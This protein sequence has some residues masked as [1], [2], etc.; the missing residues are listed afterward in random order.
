MLKQKITS[1]SRSAFTLIELLVVIAIIAILASLLLPALATAKL[2]AKRIQCVSNLRQWGI[3]FNLYAG[4]NGDSGLPGWNDPSGKGMWMVALR[5]YYNNDQIRLCPMATKTRDS[6]P[7]GQM[8]TMTGTTTLAWGIMGSGSY[9]VQPWG[10]AGLE[11]SYGE[12][13]WILNPTYV[14]PTDPT[15]GSYWHKLSAAASAKDVPMFG[16]CIWQGTTVTETDPLPPQPG[17][18]V[19]MAG[20]DEFAIPRHPG[21]RPVVLVFVD[22]SARIVGLHELFK[23]KWSTTFD[24]TYRTATTKGWP[25]WMSDYQ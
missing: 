13:D 25:Q 23:L 16:D 19:G 24:T 18:Q 21:K 2:K 14:P 1:R 4:D 10:F 20:M 22:G 12:N 7:A 3:C 11:G 6:L 8:W 17:T 15:Y 5:P 9:P